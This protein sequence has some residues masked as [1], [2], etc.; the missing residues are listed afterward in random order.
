MI[1]LGCGCLD[2]FNLNFVVDST[3]FPCSMRNLFNSFRAMMI[4]SW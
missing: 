2:A 1:A 4:L 3:G